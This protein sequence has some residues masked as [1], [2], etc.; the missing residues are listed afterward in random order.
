MFLAGRSVRV[1]AID[2]GATFHAGPARTL[3]ELPAGWVAMC[4][5]PDLQRILVT[6][7]VDGLAAPAIV[8]DLNWVTALGKP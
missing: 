8:M 5:M 6:V 1:A 3:F 4:P 2:A 7:P